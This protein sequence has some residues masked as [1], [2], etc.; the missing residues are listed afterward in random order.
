MVTGRTYLERG[1]APERTI[2]LTI[3]EI[4]AI[5]DAG[6]KRGSDEATSHEWGSS[7]ADHWTAELEG[8]LVWDRGCSETRELIDDY[9]GTERWWREFKEALEQPPASSGRSGD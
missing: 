5:Y 2:A 1:E 4:E 8:A 9:E 6:R 3:R 7:P